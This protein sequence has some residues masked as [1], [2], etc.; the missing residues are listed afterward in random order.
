MSA[1]VGAIALQPGGIIAWAVVGII[2][3]WLAG[4][5]TR[6]E[7]FG[8]FTNLIIGLLGAA[9]GGL[10]FSILNVNGTTGFWG[11]VAVAT[12][13]A[14]LLL[15]LARLAQPPH[16]RNREGAKRWRTK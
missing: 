15:A 7:G 2:A 3:R 14:L 12:V 9:I 11:S 8:C 1:A 16:R 5:L 13:G 4:L 6:S 10:V